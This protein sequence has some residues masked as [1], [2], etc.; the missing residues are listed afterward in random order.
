MEKHAFADLTVSS[1]PCDSEILVNHFS[2]NFI[3]HMA[4][5]NRARDHSKHCLQSCTPSQA[6]S[7]V[8]QPYTSLFYF[9]PKE[10]SNPDSFMWAV[11]SL[12]W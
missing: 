11:S 7:E 4:E 2:R 12:A 6:T 10:N 3:H 5:D 9:L 1:G 8:A